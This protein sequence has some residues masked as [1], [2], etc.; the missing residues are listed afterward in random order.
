MSYYVDSVSDIDVSQQ[1]RR[2]VSAVVGS[3]MIT[4][5]QT[6][7]GGCLWKNLWKISQLT[8]HSDS[9]AHCSTHGV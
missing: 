4:L 1:R 5:L 3:V 6:F 7:F 2:R 9:L 8:Y